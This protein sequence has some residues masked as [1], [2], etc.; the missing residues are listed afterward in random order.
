MPTWKVIYRLNGR[1]PY[2]EE[3][4]ASN[5]SDARRLIES[6][7]GKDVSVERCGVAKY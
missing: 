6:K 1:G 3:V 5:S 7:Y 2:S 4:Q